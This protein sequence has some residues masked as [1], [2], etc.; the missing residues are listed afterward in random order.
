[1]HIRNRFIVN[2]PRA[3]NRIVGAGL[4]HARRR[5]LTAGFIMA[6]LGACGKTETPIS[7]A[8]RIKMVEEKQKTDPNFYLEKKPAE[9]SP[10]K[11]AIAPTAVPTT[12]QAEPAKTTA[13]M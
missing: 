9:T 11:P 2:T 8:D 10:N 7:T 3:T 4:G 5:L 12:V 13:K 6:A 1:M